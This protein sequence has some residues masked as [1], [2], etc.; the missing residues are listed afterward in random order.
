MWLDG[1]LGRT[2][3]AV[4]ACGTVLARTGQHPGAAV[5]R[6]QARELTHRLGPGAPWFV[7]LPVRLR[8]RES[9]LVRGQGWRSPTEVSSVA[10][11]QLP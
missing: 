5:M 2:F 7:C 6:P 4:D 8:G 1:P 9:N 11:T 3:V 10:I